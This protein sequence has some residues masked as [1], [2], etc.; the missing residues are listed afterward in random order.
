[1]DALGVD[2]QILSVAQAQPYLPDGE[3]ASR[4][5]ALANGL[6]LEV[7][8]RHPRRFRMFAALPLPHID[9]ALAEMERVLGERE[10]VGV[11]L[12]C[13][14]N[15]IPLDDPRLAPIWEELNRRRAAVFLHPVGRDDL[16]WLAAYNLAWQVGAPFEDTVAALR[17]V[18]SGLAARCPHVKVIV[19]HLG[20][21]LPFLEARILRKNAT[22][23]LAEGLRRFYYDTVNGS[24]RSLQAAATVFDAGQLMF[25]T[26]YPYCTPEEFRHHLTF[27]EEGGFTSDTLAAIR[28]GTAARVLNLT[29]R[30]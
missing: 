19:P 15:G 16:P 18:Q 12:G 29:S 5:A 8:R 17:L 21:T 24:V 26:D 6:F 1:M 25:G 14:V 11:T 22:G 30:P 7:C 9:A 20:G 3:D 23:D 10:V 27:L 13:T 2:L 4:A 28:G